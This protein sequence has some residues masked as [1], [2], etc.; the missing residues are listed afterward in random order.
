MR[1]GGF[2]ELKIE[3]DDTG[4]IRVELPRGYFLLL[5]KQEYERGILRGKAARRREQNELRL[6]GAGNLL[7]AL[8]KE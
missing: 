2:N 6:Q 3:P 5:T 7:E 8:G 4:L 1:E